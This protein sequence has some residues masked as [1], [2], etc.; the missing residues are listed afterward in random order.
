M[1]L[2][3]L[4]EREDGSLVGEIWEFPSMEVIGYIPKIDGPAMWK[5]EIEA[6]FRAQFPKGEFREYPPAP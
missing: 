6:A 1:I 5:G 4:K 2:C 3:D